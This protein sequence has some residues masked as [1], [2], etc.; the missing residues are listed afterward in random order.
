[1]E[2]VDLIIRARYV[3]TM[4]NPLVIEDG[5]V[6][7]DNGLIKAVGRANDVLSQY[8]GEE[9]INR[10]KHI[11]MPGL[12]DAHT[13]TQQV[14][15]RSFINDERLALPP[16]WTKLLIPFEDLLTDELA[17]LSSLVSVAAMAKNGVTLFIE[18]GAPRPR[19]LIR[20]INEVGIRGV[21]TPSTFNVR[22]NEVID[23][24]EVMRRV[25]ELL[26]EAGGRVRVWCSIRQVM[27]V[28]EDLLLGLR[29]L[30]LSKGLG[31]TY[32]LGEYQGEIDYALTKY[33]A[34]PLEVFDRLGLTSIKPTVIAHAVYLSNRERAI[35][36]DRGLGIAWCPT[37]DS[38]A[39]GP[40]WLPMF[41]GVL[42]GFGSDGGAF[43]S[44]DLLHEAKVARA[45]G[46][47]LTISI[48]YDKSSF[49]SLTILRALTGWGGLLVGDNVGVINEGFKADLITLRLD[50]A[51]AL[52]I[53]DPVESVV[54]LLGGHS[55]NDVVVGGEFVVRDGRLIRIDEGELIEKL[56]DAIPE[57]R[58][59]LSNMA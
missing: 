55:V 59:K 15:L 38:I 48:A 14:L 5:A 23:A 47:A 35:V 24:K 28:T 37:V 40:H 39:M 45:V 53:Y 54:S 29:D 25:E 12:I 30:C 11:L 50:D 1:M 46:K 3:I 8:R 32:H 26:P 33:G 56:Y 13:H 51:R 2:R 7:I 49:N 19:E 9:V 43:T 6:A 42:F 21:I 58:G 18:A 34:R 36:R 22:D 20:A 57:I 44:L 31:I 17:Y 27:M 10:D 16:I 4:S 41:D 52:P